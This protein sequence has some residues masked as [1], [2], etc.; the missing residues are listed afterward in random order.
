MS[1]IILH[2]NSS[3]CSPPL[4]ETKL[5]IGMITY[6]ER[7]SDKRTSGGTSISDHHC[8]SPCNNLRHPHT[9]QLYRAERERRLGV[10]VGHTNWGPTLPLDSPSK[11]HLF[12]EKIFLKN[13]SL[14]NEKDIPQTFVLFLDCLLSCSFLFKSFLKYTITS[15][16]NESKVLHDY[17]DCVMWL[18]T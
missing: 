18:A 5:P 9:A 6:P 3:D 14:I 12:L 16:I 11:L 8:L 17:F 1:S 13:T 7:Y 4:W 15:L 10:R 2:T